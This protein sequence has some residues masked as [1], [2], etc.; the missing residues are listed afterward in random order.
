[1]NTVVMRTNTHAAAGPPLHLEGRVLTVSEQ[2]VTSHT[3]R[4]IIVAQK[5]LSCLV[6]PEVGDR[7]LISGERASSA[8]VIAVLARQPGSGVPLTLK[9]QGDTRFQCEDGALQFDAADADLVARLAWELRP[10]RV[11]TGVS[12][13][14]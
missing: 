6:E 13:T 10:H 5:A 3:A 11:Q 14:H 7:I 9:V 12:P 1:M 4:G 8:Y 2:V